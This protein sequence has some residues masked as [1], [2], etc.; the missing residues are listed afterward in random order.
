MTTIFRK[1]AN[2]GIYLSWNA[3]AP[4]T[5][6]R[7]TLKRLVAGAYIVCSANDLLQ[8]ELKYIVK[9]FHEANNCRHYIIKQIQKHGQD[10]QNQQ[11]DNARTAAIAHE[12]TLIEKK[13]HLL[14]VPYKGKKG[15]YVIKTMR[16]RMKCLLPTGIVTKSAYVGNK[17]STC[18]RV[19]DVTEFKHNHDIIYQRRCP[20]IGY[21][22]HYLGE[23]GRRITERVLNHAGKDQNSHLFKYSIGS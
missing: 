1:P 6:K 19:K 18:F 13:E 12:K 8:K 2:N 9:V 22:D 23:A 11:N 21:N 7:G 16:K 17:L 14:V 3:F 10:E 5:R 4:D 20:E 15:D